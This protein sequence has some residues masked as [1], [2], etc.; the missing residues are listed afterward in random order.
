MNATAQTAPT[1]AEF[2]ANLE[3]KVAFKISTANGT[4][5][6][7]TGAAGRS[8]SSKVKFERLVRMSEL[9]GLPIIAGMYISFAKA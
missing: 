3:A 2:A 5:W 1:A 7:H 6:P 8:I 4:A 9:T